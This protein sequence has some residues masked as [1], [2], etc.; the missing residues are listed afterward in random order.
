MLS[1]L[2]IGFFSINF[3]NCLDARDTGRGS[4]SQFNKTRAGMTLKLLQW[5]SLQ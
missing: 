2:M 4:R 3:K 1:T 5:Q